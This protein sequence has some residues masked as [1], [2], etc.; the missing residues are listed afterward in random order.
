[1]HSQRLDQLGLELS[2]PDRLLPDGLGV[3]ELGGSLALLA[4]NHDAH[5]SSLKGSSREESDTAVSTRTKVDG[6]RRGLGE[7]ARGDPVD[8]RGEDLVAERSGKRR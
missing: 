8:G 2:G 6:V 7:V 5:T 4:N 1:M 3:V